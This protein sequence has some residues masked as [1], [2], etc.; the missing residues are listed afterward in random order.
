MWNSGTL[1]SNVTSS[2]WSSSLLSGVESMFSGQK[3]LIGVEGISPDEGVK[4]NLFT[5]HYVLFHSHILNIH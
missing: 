2:T 1:T 4:Q 3:I 5:I